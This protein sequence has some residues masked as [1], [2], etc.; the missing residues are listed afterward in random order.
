MIQ[1]S[2]HF[3]GLFNDDPNTHI[4]NF[5]EICDA[6]KHYAVLND[7]IRLRLFSFS[8]KEKA[9][10]WLNSLPPGIITTWDGLAQKFLAKFFL[11]AK[12]AKMRNVITTLTQFNMESLY[13][14]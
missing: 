13:E 14:T 3:S 12:I 10:S 1:H 11:L 8:L 9:K 7:A 4:A 2:I 6:F 5:L